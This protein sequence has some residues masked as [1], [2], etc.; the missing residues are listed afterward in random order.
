[1]ILFAFALGAILFSLTLAEDKTLWYSTTAGK[2]PHINIVDYVA[3]DGSNCR[4]LI[5]TSNERDDIAGSN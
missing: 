4:H 2:L 5:K 1:M 3:N